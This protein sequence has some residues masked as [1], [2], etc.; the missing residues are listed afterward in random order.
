MMP[1]LLSWFID[2]VFAVIFIFETSAAID[3]QQTNPQG[4]FLP[5]HPNW[6]LNCADLGRKYT[7]R[8]TSRPQVDS[9][10]ARSQFDHTTV[11][12]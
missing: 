9:R 5:P 8:T 4:Y 2:L 12:F 11:G 1:V 3:L 6:V 7:L 10:F